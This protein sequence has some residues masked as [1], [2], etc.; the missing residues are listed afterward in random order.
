MKQKIAL[1]TGGAGF[2]GSNLCEYLLEKGFKVIATDNLYTGKISNLKDLKKNKN[3]KFIKKDIRK[4]IDIKGK[5]DWIFNFACPASPVWY[6]R[7]PIGTME[8]SVI[9]SINM[10][11]LAKK[12]KARIMYSSTSEIYGDPIEHPQK[13]TYKGNV[14]SVGPRACYDE[15]KRAAESL[16]MDYHRVYGLDVKIIRI[17]NTYGPKMSADDGRVVSNF[18]DQALKNEPLT[19]YGDGS[20]TRSFQYISDLIEG[21]YAMMI[22]DDFIGPVNLGNP[23]EFTVAELAEKVLSQTGAK[24]EIIKKE[25]PKDD[26]IKRKPDIELAKKMLGW[27]P[28]IHLDIGLQKTIEYFKKLK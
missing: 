10:L 21:I 5:I 17:F 6:Q 26:P 3:F 16:F 20:Q 2:V 4:K 24:S 12:K 27:Y 28:K 9:G 13:E 18:I 15:G 14:N 11:E 25:L 8:T 19:I 22:K 23:V 7:D 1:V